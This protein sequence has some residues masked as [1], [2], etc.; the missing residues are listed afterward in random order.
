M[1][2]AS[3]VISHGG[4]G[5]V[6]RALGAGTPLLISP[7]IGDMSETAMRVAWA[8]CRALATLAALPSRPAALGGAAHPGRSVVRRAGRRARRL[9]RGTTAPSAVPSWS[10][11]WRAAD[12]AA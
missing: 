8:E 11:S 6:A 5:T 12:A 9:G 10:R 7:F 3:L 4:H 1:P 2:A